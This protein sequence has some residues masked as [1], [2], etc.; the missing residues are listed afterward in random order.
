MSDANAPAGK[1]KIGFYSGTFDPIHD[2][3]VAFAQAVLEELALDQI[4]LLPERA[5][6]GKQNVTAIDARAAAMTARLKN[7]PRLTVRVLD[8]PTFSLPHTL[9]YLRAE[10]P[11]CELTFLFGSDV[12]R[13]ITSW[14]GV[15]RLLGQAHIAVGLRGDTTAAQIASYFADA[16]L[17]VRYSVHTTAHPHLRSS[18]LR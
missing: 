7:S 16:T 9:D 12:A 1:Q 3:H 15:D 18:L 5:P 10:Y 14:P 13:G 11:S 17:P 6:R 2:G 8:E 4:I